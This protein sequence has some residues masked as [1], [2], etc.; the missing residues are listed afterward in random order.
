MLCFRFAVYVCW[1]FLA[2]GRI[3]CKGKD[4]DAIID[5]GES[6]GAAE[7]ELS[8]VC[9]LKKCYGQVKF[10]PPNKPEDALL[11]MFF[12]SPDDMKE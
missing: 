3:N 12:T 4:G 7:E 11:A 10:K 6:V 8:K 5:G 1:W 9:F 2:I